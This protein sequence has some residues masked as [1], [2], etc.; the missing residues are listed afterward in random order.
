[1]MHYLILLKHNNYVITHYIIQTILH[2]LIIHLHD[3][4]IT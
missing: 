4:Y 2:F 1:M 3:L